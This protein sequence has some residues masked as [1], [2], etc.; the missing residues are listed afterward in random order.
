MEQLALA[1]FVSNGHRIDLFA[2]E[3]LEAQPGVTLRDA[4]EVIPARK[5]YRDSRGSLSSFANMFRYKLLLERGGWWIDLDTVCLRPFDFEAP[6]VIATEPDKTV[7]NGVLR[8]PAGSELMAYT[9]ER[10]RR[11]GRK[12]KKWGTTGPALLAE[13]VREKGLERYEVPH[14]TL[15]PIDWPD[16]ERFLDPD[17][18]WEFPP[19]T[20]ALH[21]WNAMWVQNRRDKE[22][23]YPANCLYEQLKRRYLPGRAQPLG[24]RQSE[25]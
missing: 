24:A 14:Q 21:L 8:V 11:L 13:A 1:S 18:R 20:Y 23:T 6:Y 25:E 17:I 15:I 16:W 5:V 7:A 12:R 19:E 4:R 3:A 9:Y 2:Y 10:C 22:A